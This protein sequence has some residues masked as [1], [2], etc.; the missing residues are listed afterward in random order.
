[1]AHDP[2]ERARVEWQSPRVPD[3]EGHAVV[4]ECVEPGALDEDGRRVDP[5]HLGDTRPCR[6]RPGH[7]AGAAADV[8]HP[9]ALR[10]RH[11]GEIG[12][13]HRLLLRVG[14]PQIE[15]VGELELDGLVGL[16]DVSVG[17]HRRVSFR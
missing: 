1:M 8:E 11:I 6:E 12:V 4:V 13:E 16:G 9:R 7:P 15:D 2:L 10:R 14:G 17:V 5:H 3:D